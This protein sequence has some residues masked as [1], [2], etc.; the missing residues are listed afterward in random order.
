MVTKSRTAV[1]LLR[2]EDLIG[3]KV[4]TDTMQSLGLRKNPNILT[5]PVGEWYFLPETLVV[6]GKSDYGGVWVAKTLSGAKRLADYVK[7]KYG[8]RTR[9]FRAYIAKVLYGNSYR[10]KTDGL[11]LSEEVNLKEKG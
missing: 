7:E 8:I 10:I 1:E 9:I 4:V 3:Y 6:P 2:S 5:Y 11:F